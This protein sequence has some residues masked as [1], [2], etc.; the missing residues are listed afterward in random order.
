MWKKH[1]AL[2]DSGIGLY[3]LRTTI[4]VVV[5]ARI[6]ERLAGWYLLHDWAIDAYFHLRWIGRCSTPSRGVYEAREDCTPGCHGYCANRVL[7]CIP[8]C[9]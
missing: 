3:G 7:H 8:I 5:K 9:D 2:Q 4:G 1:D 6:R